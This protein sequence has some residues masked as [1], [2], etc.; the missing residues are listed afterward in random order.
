MALANWSAPLVCKKPIM[1][2]AMVKL[3]VTKVKRVNSRIQEMNG[4]K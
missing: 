2:V 1:L 4:S 3:E